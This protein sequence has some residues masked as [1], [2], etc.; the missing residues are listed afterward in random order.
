MASKNVDHFC[1]TSADEK[2]GWVGCKACAE[3]AEFA[4]ARI[5]IDDAAFAFR[6]SRNAQIFCDNCGCDLREAED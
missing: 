4:T 1:Y 6:G 2:R 5:E 3:E